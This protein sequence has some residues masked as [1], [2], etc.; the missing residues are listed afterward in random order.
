M[1]SVPKSCIYYTLLLQLDFIAHDDAPYN[2]AGS[3]DVYASVK[4]KGMF[5]ATQRTEGKNPTSTIVISL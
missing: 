1:T 4:A 5:L 3:E 2:A